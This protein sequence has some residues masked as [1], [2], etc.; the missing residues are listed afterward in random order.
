ME[1]LTDGIAVSTC[2][3]EL[4]SKVV[5]DRMGITVVATQCAYKLRDVR[6]ARFRS[7]CHGQAFPIVAN[8]V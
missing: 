8:I 7:N 6:C 2:G 3:A 4:L 5:Q 1:H